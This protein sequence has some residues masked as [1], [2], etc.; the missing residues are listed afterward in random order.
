VA[1]RVPPAG[2]GL[3]GAAYCTRFGQVVWSLSGRGGERA[4]DHRQRRV[5]W[6]VGR[7]VL[8]CVVT[9][10]R[11]ADHRT[12]LAQLPRRQVDDLAER[13]VLPPPFRRAVPHRQPP[14]VALVLEAPCEQVESLGGRRPVRVD[15]PPR[16]APAGAPRHLLDQPVPLQ[17]PQVVRCS[18]CCRRVRGP[19][20]CGHR[21]HAPE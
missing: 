11:P 16:P 19:P 15:Q 12:D 21:A 3:G 13:L 1:R 2:S 5:R 8:A 9:R 7:G 6:P 18:P 20:R 17:L 10:Q 4:G 14:L